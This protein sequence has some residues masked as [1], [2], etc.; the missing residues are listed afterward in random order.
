MEIVA[1]RG[2]RLVPLLP[3]STPFASPLTPM[4][5]C[6]LRSRIHLFRSGFTAVR[7]FVLQAWSVIVQN[8]ITKRKHLHDAP[9]IDPTLTGHYIDK[10]EANEARTIRAFLSGGFPTEESARHWANT[11]ES[12]RLCGEVDTLAHRLQT[13][14]ATANARQQHQVLGKV[15]QLRA[16]APW[17]RSSPAGCQLTHLWDSLALP[18]VAATFGDGPILMEHATIL[19][20]L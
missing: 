10:L 15:D 6:P 9:A 16:E 1:R 17:A 13:C 18:C 2:D 11:D 5:L 3:I 7:N 4:V 19:R 14:G 12:C 20:T 8:D